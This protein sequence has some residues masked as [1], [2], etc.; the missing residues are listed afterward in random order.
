[1]SGREARVFRKTRTAKRHTPGLSSHCRL[2][3]W[4]WGGACWFAN[5]KW[6]KRQQKAMQQ[7][8]EPR[9]EGGPAWAAYH[10]R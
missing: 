10:G 9:A 2:S 7:T 3:L 8:D 1:M 5:K 4:C 6:R